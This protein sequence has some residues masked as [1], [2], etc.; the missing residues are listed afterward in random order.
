[1]TITADTS[2]A[3]LPVGVS[4]PLAIA[5]EEVYETPQQVWLPVPNGTNPADMQ[6]FYYHPSGEHAGWYPADNVE[7]WL[8]PNSYQYL[9]QN[10]QTYLGF[11]VNHAG[12]VQLG[13]PAP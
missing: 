1:V 9:R 12:I 7:G 10:N 8:V 11:Q 5:P 13:V 4:T 6:V 3:S 2:G